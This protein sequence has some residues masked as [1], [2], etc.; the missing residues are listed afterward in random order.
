M[1]C[2]AARAGRRKTATSAN[3]R[4]PNLND[5]VQ[6]VALDVRARGDSRRPGLT[7]ASCKEHGHG[8]EDRKLS[9]SRAEC[10]LRMRH[11]RSTSIDEDQEDRSSTSRK[12]AKIDEK[13]K[14]VLFEHIYSAEYRPCDSACRKMIDLDLWIGQRLK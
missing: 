5:R 8:S 1:N 10:T 7:R 3:P 6:S 14:F 13:K 12:E 11:T 4:S 2:E 9:V